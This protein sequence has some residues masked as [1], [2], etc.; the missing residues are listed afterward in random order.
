MSRTRETSDV[1]R[2]QVVET[3]R[4]LIATRGLKNVTIR[5]IAREVGISEG[6]IYRHFDSKRDI[7]LLLT[8]ELEAA[9]FGALEDTSRETT[10]VLDRLENF[11]RTHLS[12]AEQKRG[13]SFT[14]ITETLHLGDNELR[15][16]MLRIVSA[17][18]SRV[19]EFLIQGQ[20]LGEVKNDLDA[21][22]AATLFFGMLETTILRWV[23]S[24]QG[25][26]LAESYIPL[27][28]NYKRYVAASN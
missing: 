10:S 17:Y 7:L 9:M 23:L 25:F 11:A 19:K 18:L 3:A 16:A 28:Q 26:P 14:I 4:R 24:N 6:A 21:D 20:K 13:L 15:E 1:R 2:R 12:L 8:S 5:D 27:W 22:C